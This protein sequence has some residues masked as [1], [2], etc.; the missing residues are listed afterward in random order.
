M[1]VDVEAAGPGEHGVRRGLA[2]HGRS[3]SAKEGVI[4]RS[5]AHA[6]SLHPR[7]RAAAAGGGLAAPSVAEHQAKETNDDGQ[8]K[9]FGASGGAPLSPVGAAFKESFDGSGKGLRPVPYDE[10]S[11][12]MRGGARAPGPAEACDVA[13]GGAMADFRTWLEDQ[14]RFSESLSIVNA[15]I[16]GS[17]SKGGSSVPRTRSAAALS[18][19][20]NR[21]PSLPLSAHSGGSTAAAAASPAAD[22]ASASDSALPVSGPLLPL[23]AVV[24][25]TPGSASAAGASSGGS[26][27]G[28]MLLSRFSPLRALAR[29]AARRSRCCFSMHVHGISGLPPAFNR[30]P[31]GSARNGGGVGGGGGWEAVVTW[32]RRGMAV[33]TS[34]AEVNDGVVKFEQM[35]QLSCTLYFSSGPSSTLRFQGKPSTVVVR[36]LDRT[37]G[38]SAGAGGARG[39]AGAAGAADGRIGSSYE[40]GRHLVDLSR[41]V[42]QSL[43]E[44]DIGPHTL[45]FPL[46]GPAKGAVLL[47]TFGYEL[48]INQHSG[49]GSGG[50]YGEARVARAETRAFRAYSLPSSARTS[51]SSSPSRSSGWAGAT[52]AT[53]SSSAAWEARS[54]GGE[55]GLEEGQGE[56]PGVEEGPEATSLEREGEERRGEVGVGSGG[57]SAGGEEEFEAE[58][59][60]VKGGGGE[61]G[62]KAE[63]G[64]NV[65]SVVVSEG[66][67]ATEEQR[68]GVGGEGM[69]K[70]KEG[71]DELAGSGGAEGR[72]VTSE[73]GIDTP[74]GGSG[75]GAADNQAQDDTV[76]DVIELEDL[77]ALESSDGAESPL[78]ARGPV[79]SS[80][81]A[82]V[83]GVG[84]SSSVPHAATA[85]GAGRGEEA[86]G[87]GVPEEEMEAVTDEFLA[88]LLE[89]QL[90]PEREGE[91]PVRGSSSRSS[92][93]NGTGSSGGLSGGAAA[94]GVAGGGGLVL[95]SSAL[96]HSG[97]LSVGNNGLW[98]DKIPEEEEE[99]EGEGEG[100]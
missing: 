68:M 82:T 60:V 55:W 87:V 79:A 67:G 73:E 98:L 17:S 81:A 41:L 7:A 43:V 15:A 37:G 59:V 71:K 42:P 91:K 39:G 21:L 33:G 70:R 16:A 61:G 56:T 85:A 80:T 40:I 78:R 11:S 76:M 95:G 57:V 86:G 84:S 83:A 9:P 88:L 6:A 93:V 69:E 62:E 75:R 1:G 2:A 47:A 51:P 50:R 3:V 29:V 8:V 45:S 44:T 96:S 25:L 35:L 32:Q 5:N 65:E 63:G 90:S 52:T 34:F 54:G 38:R 10:H 12:A 100:E 13:Q 89:G 53:S 49:G 14:I 66:W 94:A 31:G 22:G 77:V 20:L 48:Q 19:S 23:H 28:G 24:P 72:G 97:M 30:P 36:V 46:D 99:G 74:G 64:E 26:G 58:R 92:S 4:Y 18:A 27:G